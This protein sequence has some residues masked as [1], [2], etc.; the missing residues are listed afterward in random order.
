M[1]CSYLNP[2]IQAFR[3]RTTHEACRSLGWKF[4]RCVYNAVL[5]EKI[6]VR[7]RGWSESENESES[8]AAAASESCI[9]TERLI[10]SLLLKHC[11]NHLVLVRKLMG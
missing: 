6:P 7:Y 8:V 2:G 11:N 10:S 3:D 5:S 1:V 4:A 9:Y